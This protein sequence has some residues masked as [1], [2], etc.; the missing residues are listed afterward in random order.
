MAL[1]A[2]RIAADAHTSGFAA[3][4]SLTELAGSGTAA[5][6]GTAHWLEAAGARLARELAPR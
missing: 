5:M 6:A 2:G 3:T 1:V 4:A